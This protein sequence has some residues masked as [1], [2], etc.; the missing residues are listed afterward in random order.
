MTDVLHDLVDVDR[1]LVRWLAGSEQGVDERGESICL[2]DD[3]RR[4][5]VQRRLLELSL[6]Q[7]RRTAQAAERVLD[8]VRELA[9]HRAAATELGEQRV[10][11]RDAL[12]VRGVGQL[13]EHPA[14]ASRV[15]ERC[16]GNVEYTRQRTRA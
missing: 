1:L 8:L 13:H 3:H 11:A 12:V 10:L 7:L 16:H 2:G 6:E 9:N 15:V 4:V 5:L 14:S